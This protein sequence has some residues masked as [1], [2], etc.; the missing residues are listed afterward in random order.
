MVFFHDCLGIIV[1]RFG[2][3]SIMW[4]V[5][6]IIGLMHLLF[7]LIDSPWWLVPVGVLP[8]FLFSTY[9]SAMTSY[10]S[11]VST[12]GTAACVQALISSAYDGLGASSGNFVAG[13]LFYYIDR[14]TVFLSYALSAL[15]LSFLF[16]CFN[17]ITN[18]DKNEKSVK[19]NTC[20]S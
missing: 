5:L 11:S 10:A 19:D 16:M 15:F 18:D 9:Y 7:S 8:G 3:K 2:I 17:H 1:E 6:F 13:L 4:L 12:P 14:K 20:N